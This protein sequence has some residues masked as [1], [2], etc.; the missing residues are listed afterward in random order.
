M[1]GLEMVSRGEGAAGRSTTL[2]LALGVAAGVAY[3]RHAR[4]TE[5]PILDFRM[6]RIPTFGL[7]VLGGSL[8]RITAGAVPFLLPMMMQVG[9]GMSAARSGLIT[10]STAAGSFLMKMV[11]SPIL[12]KFGFRRT[13]VWNSLIATGFLGILA[14]FRPGWPVLAIHAVLL[15]GGFFQSLQF[16]ALN[17]IAYADI[18]QARMSSATSFYATFQQMTLSVGICISSGVLALSIAIGRHGGPH[19]ADFSVAF[20]AVTAISLMASPVLARLPANAGALMS[21]HVEKPEGGGADPFGTPA[22]PEP[23]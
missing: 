23:S 17:T 5:H 10:F 3:A 22:A 18:P 15:V 2:I 13:L 20:L 12:R 8:T 11:T 16:T 7:S 4:W 6:M 1:Y 21:G 9:F 19:L 14:A